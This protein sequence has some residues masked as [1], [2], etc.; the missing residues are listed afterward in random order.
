MKNLAPILYGADSV[1]QGASPDEL[2]LSLPALLGYYHFGRGCAHWSFQSYE[3][4][5]GPEFFS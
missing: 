3:V 5:S 1:L 2:G 4:H